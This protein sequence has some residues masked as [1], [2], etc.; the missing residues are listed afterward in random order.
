MQPRILFISNYPELS[1][2]ALQLSKKLDVPMHIKEGGLMK[3]GHLY[4]KS[5]EDNYDVFISH[6]A[7]AA[8]ISNLIRKKP[9]LSIRVTVTDILKAFEEAVTFNKP[10]VLVCYRS[11]ELDELDKFGKLLKNI[12]Y[13]T[14]YYSDKNECK[15]QINKAVSLTEHVL[16]S[17]GSCVKEIADEKNL[18]CIT[19]RSNIESVKQTI[20]AAKNIIELSDNEKFRVQKLQS[21]IDYSSEGIVSIDQNKRINTINAVA[22]DILN[23]KGTN[24]IGSIIYD[25]HVPSILSNMYADGSYINNELLRL[26]DSAFLINRIPLTQGDAPAETLIVFQNI[27]EL[28]KKMS[29]ARKQLHLNGLVAQYSFDNI[30]G[31]GQ[32]IKKIKMMASKFA[33][34]SATI[35]IE[36]ETGTGKELFAQSIHNASNRKDG[37][38]VAVNC[39]TLSETL[40]ESELFGYEEGAFTGAR[41]GG[42]IGLLELAQQGTIFMDEIGEISPQLQ[43]R[44]LR[45]LQEKE[46]LR[47]GGNRI[48]NVDVRFI[49]ATNKNLYQL[50]KEGKFREDLYYRLNILNLF[51]PALRERG[52]DIPLLIDFFINKRNKQFKNITIDREGLRLL[53]Q[54]DWLGNIRELQN[55]LEKMLVLADSPKI[56]ATFIRQLLRDHCARRDKTPVIGQ[57]DTITIPVGSLKSMETEIFEEL[58]RRCDGNQNLVSKKLGI[59]RTTIWSRLND[60]KLQ[61]PI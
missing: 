37:P 24:L 6:G 40:L 46:I 51:L 12:S 55:F 60:A 9:V 27:S 49:A 59:S 2:Q 39:A 36:G 25:S 32:T 57:T 45:A 34:S 14:L 47:I 52:E 35:L 53:Q 41:K 50:M 15:Q 56:E 1:L 10:I 4:A 16:V 54:Y 28:Q 30:I 7:S 22:T 29:N 33:K 21:I 20:I 3:D 11:S 31:Q 5:Q 13:K 17:L 18:K 44:L 61:K 23:V 26:G 43:S 38:F 8:A 48:I 42:K 58:L 19:I